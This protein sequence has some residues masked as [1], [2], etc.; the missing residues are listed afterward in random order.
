V[1]KKISSGSPEYEGPYSSPIYTP[2]LPSK[3]D[4]LDYS[5]QKEKKADQSDSITCI[6]F[7]E[8]KMQTASYTS[9]VYLFVNHAGRLDV[10]HNNLCQ[11]EREDRTI[12]NKPVANISDDSTCRGDT[13]RDKP[14]ANIPEGSM[15]RGVYQNEGCKMGQEDSTLRNNP[16]ASIPDDSTCSGVY[17]N[18]ACNIGQEDC[19]ICDKPADKTPEDSTCR[20][21]NQNKA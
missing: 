4:P 18:K 10:C 1:T 21:I 14:T 8:I 2:R 13:I 9:Q 12:H 11:M 5:C 16:E 20:F 17:Q 3:E 19:P 7:N 6:T 15:C